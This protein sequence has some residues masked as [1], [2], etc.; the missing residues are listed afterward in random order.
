MCQT[1]IS[2]KASLSKNMGFNKEISCYLFVK[3]ICNMIN[4]YCCKWKIIINTTI[5]GISSPSVL[6]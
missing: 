2:K 3:C 4:D 5:S 1:N 6:V